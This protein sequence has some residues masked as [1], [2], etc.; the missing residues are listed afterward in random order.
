MKIPTVKIEADTEAGF[1]VINEADFD[2]KKHKPFTEQKA[3]PK[4][5]R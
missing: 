2:P 3:R 4:K 1:A 5:A